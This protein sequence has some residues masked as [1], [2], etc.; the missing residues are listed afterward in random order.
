[1]PW[2]AGSPDADAKVWQPVSLS[3]PVLLS[4]P[5]V[6]PALP[7]ENKSRFPL[8]IREEVQNKN[9]ILPK[10]IFYSF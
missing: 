2:Y 9:L 4:V 1:M 5:L 3:F 6:F 7:K 8:R 10:E